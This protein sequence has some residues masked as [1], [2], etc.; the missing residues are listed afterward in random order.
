MARRLAL[1][2]ITA[3]ALLAA[4]AT[5]ALA[6]AGAPGTTFPEQPGTHPANA[7]RAITTNPGTGAGGAFT[8][9]ASPTAQII[10]T[11]LLTDACFGG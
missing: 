7:C 8:T 6:N 11:G 5:P 3:A 2:A 4:V 1:S 9:N 10:A